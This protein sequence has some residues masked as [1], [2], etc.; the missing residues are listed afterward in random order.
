MSMLNGGLAG[1][2]HMLHSHD[3]PWTIL[4]S[5]HYRTL[6]LTGTID[7]NTCLATLTAFT[8]NRALL[9]ADLTHQASLK[10]RL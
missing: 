1:P 10:P 9:S 5:V 6:Q 3:Y 7:G 4:Y 8:L 2:T